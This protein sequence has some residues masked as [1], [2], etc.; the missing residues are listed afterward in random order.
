MAINLRSPEL[1]RALAELCQLTGKGTTALLK[2]LVHQ[3]LSQAR[4]QAQQES[5]QLFQD[6]LAIADQGRRDWEA[7]GSPDFGEV[8]LYDAESGLPA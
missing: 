4:Q 7:A 5:E 8:D 6:L 3:A 1:E 2:E